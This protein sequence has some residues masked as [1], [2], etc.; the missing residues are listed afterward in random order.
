MAQQIVGNTLIVQ[1]CVAPETT[2]T[3]ITPC[4]TTVPTLEISSP[5]RVRR[6]VPPISLPMAR[7]RRWLE[8]AHGSPIS[9]LSPA[10]PQYRVFYQS[11]G[12]IDTG[13]L[14][15]DGT[16]LQIAPVKG[17][18]PPNFLI[19]LNSAALQSVKSAINF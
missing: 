4:P 2:G 11:N 5:T 1:D 16:P 18:T 6:T 13:F 14:I 19:L 10:T 15:K 9:A 17:G 8:F 7:S 3:N 12:G